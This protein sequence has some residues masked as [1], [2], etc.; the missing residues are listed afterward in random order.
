MDFRSLEERFLDEALS[1][2]KSDVILQFAFM[3]DPRTSRSHALDKYKIETSLS[4]LQSQGRLKVLQVNDDVG[5]SPL[6]RLQLG[7]LEH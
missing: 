4:S 2:G 5:Y 3:P 6:S 1:I 7:D